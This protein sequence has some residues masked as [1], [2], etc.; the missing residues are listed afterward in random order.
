LPVRAQ[1]PP[2]FFGKSPSFREKTGTCEEFN[3]HSTRITG[4]QRADRQF[5]FGTQEFDLTA[6]LADWPKTRR[7]ANH[8]STFF[9]AALLNFL[10]TRS[11]LRP[12]FVY[13]LADICGGVNGTAAD[14]QD[15][16]SDHAR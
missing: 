16:I 7:S 14:I 4:K 6:E 9:F 15:D 2:C 1:S 10:M 12:G 13:H 5:K 11:R 3:P 8:A